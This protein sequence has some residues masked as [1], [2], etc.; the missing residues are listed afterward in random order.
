LA[1]NPS[2][3]LADEPTGNLDTA[4][5]NEIQ[6]LFFELRKR[7]GQTFIIVT[8]DETLASMSDRKIVMSDGRI[9]R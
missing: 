2:V 7:T 5:R 3:V 8:H 1:N 6:N 9:V 4:T